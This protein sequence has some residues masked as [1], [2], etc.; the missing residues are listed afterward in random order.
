MVSVDLKIVTKMAFAGFIVCGWLLWIRA[1]MQ[2]AYLMDEVWVS[3]NALDMCVGAIREYG[4][5]ADSLLTALSN[6][7]TTV[8][9]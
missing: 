8:I 4:Q 9:P 5:E 7:S 3:I 1:E 6:M 2:L